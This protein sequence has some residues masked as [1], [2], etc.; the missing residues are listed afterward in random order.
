MKTESNP[1]RKETERLRS[2]HEKK[3]SESRQKRP[4]RRS[5]SK[6]G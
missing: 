2:E 5:G 1:K 6:R 4:Q 3:W